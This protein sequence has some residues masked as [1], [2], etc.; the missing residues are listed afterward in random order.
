MNKGLLLDRDGVI[1]VDHGYTIKAAQ[2]EFIPGIFD[3]VRRAK[4]AAYKV[5]IVTNQSGIGR[6]YYSEDD[7]HQLT[8]WMLEQFA[9]NHAVIDKVY[10]CP[11]HPSQ[12]K[13]VYRKDCACRKPQPG[14]L[15]QAASDF[16]LDLSQSV[17][18]GDNPSDMQ[19]AQAATVGRKI[20]FN[21]TLVVSADIE[22]VSQL[23]HIILT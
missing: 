14:M 5:V 22:Q 17:M 9:D 1:N 7:F 11:H 20:L 8:Q 19:A 10:F 2:F 15:L 4:A 16:N 13:S 23:Q 12:A 21:S 3:L 18:V 6:G